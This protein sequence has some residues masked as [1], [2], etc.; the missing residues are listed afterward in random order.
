MKKFFKILGILFLIIILSAFLLPFIFKGKIEALVRSEINKQVNA[1]INYTDIDLSLFKHFPK[2]SIDVLNLSITG[3]DQFEG[4]TL[5]YITQLSTTVDLT[6]VIS[7]KEIGVKEILIHQ[8]S[9]LLK[10]NKNGLSNWDIVPTEETAPEKADKPSGEMVIDLEKIEIINSK[11]QYVD[12]EGDM[13][14]STSP[15]NFSLTGEMKGAN[16]LLDYSGNVANIFFEKEGSNYVKNIQVDL[17]GQLAAN[18]DEMSF[19]FLENEFMINQLPLSFDGKFILGDDQ[20]DMDINFK[21]KSSEFEKILGFIPEDYQEYLKGVK[22]SGQLTFN[23]FV[24]GTY[25]EDTFPAIKIN[26]AAING[27]LQYPSLPEKV[28]N[29]GIKM[30]LEKPQGDFDLFVVN[31]SEFHAEAAG[32][33][34]DATLRLNNLMSD[35]EIDLKA[36]GNIDFQSLGKAIPMEDILLKGKLNANLELSGKTSALENKEYEKFRTSGTATLK[37]F[38]FRSK[39]L[40]QPFYVSSA[41]MSMNPKS[42]SLTKFNGTM[43]HSDIGLKGKLA[44]YLEYFLKDGTLKGNLSLTSNYID[45]NELM[46]VVISDDS[47]SV[48]KQEVSATIPSSK[49]EAPMEAIE[50]PKNVDLNINANVKTILYSQIPITTTTGKLK[51]INQQAILENLSLNLLQGSAGMKGTYNTVNKNQPEYDMSFNLNRIDLPSAYKSL[52]GARQFLP[53]SKNS[54]GKFSASMNLTGLLTENMELMVPSING[55]GTFSSHNVVVEGAKVLDELAKALKNKELKHLKVDDFTANFII[56]KGELIIKPFTTKLA[57]QRTVIQG[58]QSPDMKLNYTLDMTVRRKD[59]GEDFNNL[60]N[61]LPGSENIEYLDVGINIVGTIDNPIVKPDFSK[62][63]KQ[64]KEEVKKKS[65]EE[66]DKAIDD[67]KKE[68]EKGL[69]RLFK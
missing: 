39:N 27:S 58:R 38:E 30:I 2:F 42:L 11:V 9:I 50:I 57:G 16:T 5:A 48:S 13:H 68:I 53:L 66:I 8:P 44:N 41:E 46:T 14:F 1:K 4:D 32:N 35:M 33:P 25:N 37:D 28:E 65:K 54:T 3:I 20:Y 36:K 6:D 31:V 15:V 55:S 17:Q 51:I 22:T 40:T 52:A 18:F 23:G 56:E 64:I 45:V 43:G 34:I 29:I 19:S 49:E 47:L 21:T 63:Q 61:F 60:F 69:K 7:S 59:L 26:L 67:A 12:E 10:R 24:K 62:A